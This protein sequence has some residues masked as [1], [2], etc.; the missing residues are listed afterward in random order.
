MKQSVV[1]YLRFGEF[2][3]FV[4]PGLRW[5]PT[6]ID[7]VVPVDVQTVRDMP[8]AG[9]MLTEDENVVTVEMVVQ[10]RVVEPYKYYLRGDQAQSSL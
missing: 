7:T 6:F 3:Q 8:S 1:L 5:K 2:N 4:E 10:Y 9:S